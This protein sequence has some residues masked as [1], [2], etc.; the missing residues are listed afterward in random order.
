M[1]LH[2]AVGESELKAVHILGEEELVVGEVFLGG[3]REPGVGIHQFHLLSPRPQRDR[4]QRVAAFVQQPCA[5]ESGF[6]G[7]TVTVM[8]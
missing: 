6:A 2:G 5:C 8:G 1:D 4:A 7:G 3:E